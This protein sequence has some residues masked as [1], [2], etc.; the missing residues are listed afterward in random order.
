MGAVYNGNLITSRK[1]DLDYLI[2]C[3]KYEDY[4]IT[5]KANVFN[6]YK[7]LLVD[8]DYTKRLPEEIDID[9]WNEALENLEPEI[10]AHDDSKYSDEEFEPYRRHFDKTEM[11]A[12]RDRENP[13]QAKYVEEE[14]EKAWAH[15]F[16]MNPHH[17]EF[18]NHTDMVNGQLIPSL[19]PRKDGPRDMDLLNILHM[20]CDWSGMSLKFRQKYSPVSW[21]NTQATDERKVMSEKTR[22]LVYLILSMMF[23]EEEVIE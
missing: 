19:T 20:I 3:N 15:H 18:W 21:Y 7:H 13:E 23:P 8:E 2:Q 4:I 22:H 17:P 11:E 10:K 6:A 12:M 9:E 16:L 5:H 14:Y 1:D